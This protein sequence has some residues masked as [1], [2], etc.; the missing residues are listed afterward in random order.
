[1]VKILHV[2]PKLC[3]KLCS[4]H[5]WAFFFSDYRTRRSQSTSKCNKFVCA[6]F[7][8]LHFHRRKSL[9][10]KLE[11]QECRVISYNLS[12]YLNLPIINS[13]NQVTLLGVDT[14]VWREG[15]GCGKKLLGKAC[16]RPR[17]RIP[18]RNLPRR[19]GYHHL[20]YHPWQTCRQ[21]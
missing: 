5:L 20:P 10:R 2:S 6:Y 8:V 11:L 16:Y 7:I 21:Y 4:L 19:K 13:S 18:P 3:V 14:G 1:M 9:F 17:G 15:G 12:G